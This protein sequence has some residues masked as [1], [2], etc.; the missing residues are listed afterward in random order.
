ML[1]CSPISSFLSGGCYLTRCGAAKLRNSR[2]VTIFVFFQNF[3]KCRKF[4]VTR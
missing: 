4:P 2:E 1:R 3:G